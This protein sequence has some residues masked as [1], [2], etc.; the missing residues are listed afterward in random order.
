MNKRIEL[1]Y[2]SVRLHSIQTALAPEDI[3]KFVEGYNSD[4]YFSRIRKKIQNEENWNSPSQSLFSE[5]DNGSLFFEDWNG[6]LRLCVPKDQQVEIMSEIHDNLTEAAHAGYHKI[7]NRLASIY[8]WPRMSRHL[9][10][11]YWKL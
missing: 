9:K 7:Y 4:S 8:Y 10:K 2:L 6:N 11:V 1:K 5:N 3:S